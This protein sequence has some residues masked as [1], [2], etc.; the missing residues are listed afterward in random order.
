MTHRRICILL[1]LL[2]VTCAASAENWGQWR[3]P[4]QLGVTDIENL[5]V[6]WDDDENIAWKTKMPGPGSS[7]PVRYQGRIFV[8]SFSGYD[9]GIG[10]KKKKQGAE[11]TL[12]YHVTCLDPA[13]GSIIWSKEL[14]PI[15]TVNQQSRNLAFHGWATP[16]PLAEENR[17]YV[18]FGT[19]GLFCFD[20]DGKELWKTSIGTNNPDWGYA[21]SLADHD[22]ML[23]VNASV[24]SQRLMALDKSNGEVIWEN[25][26]GFGPKMNGL[27]RSTPLVFRNAQGQWRISIVAPGQHLNVYDPASGQLL[28]QVKNVSKGYASNTPVPNEDGSVL[29]CLAGG[30]HGEV[31]ATAV[32]T[33]SDVKDRIIWQHRRRGVA[34]IPPV[35]YNKRI[36]YGAYGSERPHGVSCFGCLDP[37]TGEVIYEKKIDQIEEARDFVYTPTFAG[38]GKIYIQT[39]VTGLFVLDATSPQYKLLAVN[40]LDEDKVQTEMKLTRRSP[41]QS[42][43]GFNAMPVPLP[44]GRLLLRGYWGVYCVEAAK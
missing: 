15:N 11:K 12:R 44:D 3:G 8:T 26:H 10:P 42:G 32:R 19:G 27:T 33:G 14:K 5:P 31:A 23:I 21:A 1:S 25:G 24:E 7:Q 34:L 40:L 35:L 6:H 4:R 9:P 29:Y 17:L 37:A 20:H 22:N 38:D 30:S 36:Y 2:A 16:T 39:Q 13:N 28:W 41:N 18:S 43:N